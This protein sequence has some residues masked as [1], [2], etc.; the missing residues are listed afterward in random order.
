M[1]DDVCW[2]AC[3]GIAGRLAVMPRPRAG[4]WLA[5][6]I[7]GWKRQGIDIVACLLEQHEIREL[8]LQGE[9]ELCASHGIELLSFPIADRGV[10]G[11]GAAAPSLVRRLAQDLAKG[12][13]VAVHCRAGIGRSALIAASVMV[14]CGHG[15]A[16]ALALIAAARCCP[17]PD[18]EDQRAWIMALRP[19]SP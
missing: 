6:E 2:I 15:P 3:E 19:Q 8:D 9:A 16:R 12:R 17:V 7:A 13:S 10:P 1:R 4:D 11:S 14:A 5:D 18:T